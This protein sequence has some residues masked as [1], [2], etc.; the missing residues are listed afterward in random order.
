MKPSSYPDD[1]QVVFEWYRFNVYERKK[2]E[3][4][5][6]EYTYHNIHRKESVSIFATQWESILL[7]KFTGSYQG[8]YI[9]VFWWIIDQR[10]DDYM[11]IAEEELL[12]EAGMKSNQRS[13]YK[14]YQYHWV[15]WQV[16]FVIAKNCKTITSQSLS[17]AEG[18]VE[19]LKVTLDEFLTMAINDQIKW[20]P[21]C[22]VD[23]CK[24]YYDPLLKENFRN[25]LFN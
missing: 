25:L 13:L 6:K 11:K 16:H 10:W 2:I 18:A 1:A 19:I 20:I 23:L 22:L 5:D 17:G 12:E 24:I 9:G 15:K 7:P 3:S 21:D 8:D 4:D 14:T